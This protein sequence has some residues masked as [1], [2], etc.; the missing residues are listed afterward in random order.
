VD[1]DPAAAAAISNRSLTAMCKYSRWRRQYVT[2][3]F[4]SQALLARAHPIRHCIRLSDELIDIGGRR[5]R[6]VSAGSGAPVV[7]L[8]AG[9]GGFSAV[10]GPVM[11]GVAKFTR[12]IA[13][14]RAGLGRSDPP[15]RGEPRTSANAVADLHALLH[16]A[17]IE[18][19]YVICGHSYGGFHARLYTSRYPAEVAGLVLVDADVEEEWSRALPDQ[20]RRGLELVTGLLRVA[21]NVARFGVPQVAVRVLAPSA[22]RALPRAERREM[23]R[24]GFTR[25]ALRTLHNEFESLDDS[26]AQLRTS[27][28][29]LGDR[30]LVVIRHGIA[31]HRLP[32]TSREQHAEIERALEAMQRRMAMWS[33]RGRLIMAEKSRHDIHIDEPDVVIHAIHDVV[34][35]VRAAAGLGSKGQEL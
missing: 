2:G 29:D 19:P 22:V 13:Y 24:Y 30:P 1:V 23:M 27:K 12:V 11:R 4:A 25:T 6:M 18:P 15:P 20:H 14:D 32:G 7:I 31:P 9:A 10:W 21:H 34:R 5:L 26:A 17:R 3:C 33:R 35:A 28:R 16:A 8:E